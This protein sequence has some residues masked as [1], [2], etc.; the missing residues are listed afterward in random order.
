VQALLD[1]LDSEIK[2]IPG[3]VQNLQAKLKRATVKQD[4]LQAILPDKKRA[5]EL[6]REVH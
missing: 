2:K 4:K 1:D 3:K 6:R 5:D